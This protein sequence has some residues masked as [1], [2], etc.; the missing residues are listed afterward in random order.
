LA[1]CHK[2]FA[3]H[4]C[5]TMNWALGFRELGWDV[6]IT[7]AVS[8]SELSPPDPG[9][10]RSPQEEF[11]HAT[12]AEFGFGDRQCLLI[13]GKS[14]DLEAFRDFAAG[15]DLFINYSGQYKRLD[16]LGPRVTKAYLDVDPGFTQ[17]W[18]ELFGTDMNL[19][20]H[21]V[22]LTVGTTLNAPTALLPRLGR[23]WIPTPP[24]VVADY[25]RERAAAALAAAG[26]EAWTAIA[27]WY[28]YHEMEWQGRR[29][30][31]KRE[32]LMEMRL[33]P[34]STKH[35]CG[36]ASDLG[37]DWDDY[38]SF[39]EGGWEF[40][41]AKEVCRNV[42]TYLDFIA[43]SRGEIGIAKHGYVASR[44]GWMSDRSVVYLAMGRPVILQETGWTDAISSQPGMLVFHDA[45]EGGRAIDHIESAYESH[46]AAALSLARQAFSARQILGSLASRIL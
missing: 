42:E 12:A 15:A 4:T 43:K 21:D 31:G 25:W 16:L 35:R 14:P 17:L 41:S 7:E 44:A 39:S 34:R 9:R 27:H 46:S 6:W 11:W 5:S 23:E 40:Y 29:Y 33:L 26:G 1:R 38:P 30:G 18:V 20:G 22:F 3:G 45:G 2:A 19:D 24:P 36:I 32:C 13:D 10:D 8:S 28:G 37:P